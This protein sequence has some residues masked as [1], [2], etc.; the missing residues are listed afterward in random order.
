MVKPIKIALLG[1]GNVGAGVWRIL[2]QNGAAI[3]GRAGGP[4][5]I[6]GIAVRDVNKTRLVDVPA[7][8][9]TTDPMPLIA[10]P[11]I[12]IVVETI[13]CPGGDTGPAGRF[14]IEALKRGKHVV[15]ANK[16][17][18]AKHGAAFFRAAAEGGGSLYYEG[19]VAGGI[20]I[21]KAFKESLAANQV[22]TIMGIINGTTN[23]MLTRMDKEGLEFADVL[24]QAQKLGYAEADPTSDVEGHDAAYKLALL[25]SIA[26]EAEINIDDV[27]REGITRITAEDL[28]SAR[29]LGF[30]VKLLAIAKQ[31]A[32]GIEARVH[33]TLIP[34]SHPLAAVGDVFNAVFV[35]GDAVGDLMFYGRGAG[36]MPTGSAVVADCIDAALNIRRGVGAPRN[37]RPPERKA[38]KPI[39]EVTARFYLNFKVIDRPGVLAAIASILGQNNVSIESVIQKGRRQDPVGLVIV[40]HSVLERDIRRALAAI[41][42]LSMVRAIANVMRVEGE[43]S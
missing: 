17:A 42:E 37:G 14:I 7:A 8:L 18:L 1:L 11:D 24:A 10:D 33:P 27:Y 31:D 2:Q 35:Q 29:E 22:Q 38:I 30:A 20:P 9:L 12:P 36:M 4:L 26:F 13:G 3:A 16:E 23:Y 6:V 5:E 28:Q 40:T 39:E 41:S 43:N 15:T 19:A 32:T 25:A 21:V 34:L